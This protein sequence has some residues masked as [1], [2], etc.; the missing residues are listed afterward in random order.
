M[1]DIFVATDNLKASF[2]AR[3]PSSFELEMFS[4]VKIQSIELFF[5]F[6]PGKKVFDLEC[7]ELHFFI[8]VLLIG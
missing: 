2:V 1:R 4:K 5:L 8:I 7:E 6:A 3:F